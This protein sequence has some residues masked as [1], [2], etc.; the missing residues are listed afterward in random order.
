MSIDGWPPF[1]DDRAAFARALRELLQR[2]REG[3]FISGP[4]MD[5]RLARMISR[6]RRQYEQ[7]VPPTDNCR[8]QDFRRHHASD[9]RSGASQRGTAQRYATMPKSSASD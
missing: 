7:G 5:A 3:P 6:K 9:R 1:T 8:Q 2:R 4:E